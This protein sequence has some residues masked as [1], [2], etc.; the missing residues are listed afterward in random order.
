MLPSMTLLRGMT[1]RDTRRTGLARL[2]GRD[3]KQG[4][5]SKTSPSRADPHR[6]SASAE[7]QATNSVWTIATCHSTCV[8]KRCVRTSATTG[9]ARTR[10]AEG[11]AAL[12][13]RSTASR[14]ACLVQVNSDKTHVE[15]N[16][17]AHSPSP[18]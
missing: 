3:F 16:R 12:S 5:S 9:H 2:G 4:S 15:R 1:A 14:V 13:L 8:V 18:T 11:V 6:Q 7:R 17:S 10:C